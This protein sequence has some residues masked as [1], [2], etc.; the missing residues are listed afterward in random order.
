LDFA[1]S[2]GTHE[3]SG[4]D[5]VDV[6]G[7]GTDGGDEAA[8]ALDV[9]ARQDRFPAGVRL[10][11]GI[12][13]LDGFLHP[14]GIALDDHERDRLPG[15]LAR[16]D[17]PDASKAADD[18]VLIELVQHAFAAPV[19]PARQEVA[20]HEARHEE[21]ERVEDGGDADRQHDHREEL[22]GPRQRADLAV[23]DGRHGDGTTLRSA[24]TRTSRRG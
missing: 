7:V 24:Y 18:E 22:T 1:S 2:V 15:E 16:D 3:A 5:G 9:D 13:L 20:L 8:G 4:Q 12:A 6:L 17:L 10:D 11:R 23:P 21:R 19:V 14:L